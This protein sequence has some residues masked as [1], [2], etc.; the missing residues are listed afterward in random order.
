MKLPADSD[1]RKLTTFIALKF[2]GYR[3]L[4]LGQTGHSATMWM[5]QVVRPLLILE[6]TGSALQVGLVVSIRM[7]PQ[8]LFGLLAGVIADRYDK[9]KVL[10]LSQ[11]ITLLTHV[12]MAT[13]LLTGNLEVWHVYVTAFIAG[14]SMAFNQPARQSLVPRLVPPE[15]L[16]NAFS[17]NTAAMN[18]TRVF[19][20][21]LAGILLIFFNY[22]QVFLL[23][24]LI[25]VFVIWTTYKIK[26]N[27]NVP[28]DTP[29]T[30]TTLLTDFTD[31]FRYILRNP[32]LLYLVALA[33]LLF[34][35][36]LPYQQVFIP[37]IALDV[38]EIGRSGA[39]W[40]LAFTGVGAL[41]GSLTIA[42]VTQLKGRGFILMGLL[43]VF[44]ASL[45]LLAQSRW[46]AISAL[47]L[48]ITGGTA[49]AFLT[50]TTSLLLEKTLPAYHGRVV[51]LMSLDRGLVS[52][53]AI[54]AGALAESLG[55]RYGLT[56]L[57]GAC[58]VFT[59]LMFLL[60]RSL[61]KIS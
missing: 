39:G 24:A 9:R 7:I 15:V 40:L 44:G 2:P 11:T 59:V 50:L 20:A 60:F 13:L 21:S 6:L 10:M 33:L 25:F 32:V 42:S 34:I 27:K 23:N 38:L 58:I 18:I 16:L 28:G 49:T 37:L 46:F 52:L 55:P 29:Q 45:G 35:F 22:G 56:I 3:Y 36:G 17:L 12:V 26:M 1:K 31:G 54:L 4:W 30:Q 57:A 51:S 61:R 43:L 8:L 19:G 5:E 48:V 47:A 41:I 14:S 53:G